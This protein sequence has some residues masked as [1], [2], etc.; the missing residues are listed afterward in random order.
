MRSTYSKS[1]TFDFFFCV[2]KK[3]API[4]FAPLLGLLRSPRQRA[5]G[6]RCTNLLGYLHR[7]LRRKF[8]VLSPWPTRASTFWPLSIM[9]LTIDA[10]P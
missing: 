3:N 7:A 8:G 6:Y 4:S 5:W 2:G 9:A 10:I 1:V